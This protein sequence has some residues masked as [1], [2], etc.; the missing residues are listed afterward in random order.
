MKINKS[1]NK[2]KK[3]R[4]GHIFYY[5]DYIGEKCRLGFLG[6]H[7]NDCWPTTLYLLGF[8]TRTMAERFALDTNYVTKELG[9]RS[10]III[11]WFNEALEEEHSY[12]LL[13][14]SENVSFF[15]NKWFMTYLNFLMPYRY[16]GMPI[17]YEVY[18]QNGD[19]LG[20]HAY[21][22]VRNGNNA[23]RILDAQ[24]GINIPLRNIFDLLSTLPQRDSYIGDQRIANVRVY[25]FMQS[26]LNREWHDRTDN[27]NYNVSPF[28]SNFYGVANNDV[29][30]RMMYNKLE[31][32]YENGG[33]NKGNYENGGN[34]EENNEN[35]GNNE[36]NY[37]NGR[38]NGG[39]N[40]GNNEEEWYEGYNNNY[41]EENYNVNTGGWNNENEEN[42]EL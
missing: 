42:N 9:T 3:K 34:N 24:Q 27:G 8:L 37:E 28:H 26:N 25:C 6:M 18:N 21:C 23:F 30:A 22:I 15:N 10:E 32:N 31:N 5:E 2:T 12:D 16:L 13:Y 38:N 4:G 35:G 17:T 41:N 39:N 14:D 7:E 36:G 40:E 29:R 11:E 20:G 1:N 19:V 33:N